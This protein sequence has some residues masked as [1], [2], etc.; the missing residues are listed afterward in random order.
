MRSVKADDE[1]T[2]GRGGQ[3]DT[4]PRPRRGPGVYVR[5]SRQLIGAKGAGGRRRQWRKRAASAPATNGPSRY[6]RR[7][8]D[9]ALNSSFD[10]AFLARN[11]HRRERSDERSSTASLGSIAVRLPDRVRPDTDAGSRGSS[12]TPSMS[13]FEGDLFLGRK[14]RASA[15]SAVGR[16]PSRERRARSSGV[17]ASRRCKAGTGFQPLC[18]QMP[19]CT[20]KPFCT[21]GN[22]ANA[23][24]R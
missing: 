7:T 17:A 2:T 21:G 16:R 19:S 5:P 12:S 23:E 4:A 11:N 14:R 15:P 13:S 8:L 3:A 9:K 18:C 10:S 22:E 6:Q 1:R 20:P 24:E